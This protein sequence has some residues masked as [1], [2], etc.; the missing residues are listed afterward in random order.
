MTTAMH[1]RMRLPLFSV[2]FIEKSQ[3]TEIKLLLQSVKVDT[4]ESGTKTYQP[5]KRAL[6]MRPGLLVVVLLCGMNASHA[7]SSLEQIDR[8]AEVYAGLL[9]YRPAALPGPRS[10]GLVEI[11]AELDLLPPVNNQIGAKAEPVQTSPVIGRARIDW[12]PLSGLRLGAYLIPPVSILGSTARMLG[13]QVEYGCGR[14][15]I[16][17]S[18]RVFVTQGTVTGSFT[19]SGA[20][21]QFRVSATGAD[22]RSGWSTGKWMLYAGLGQGRNQTQFRMGTDGAIID[23]QRDYSYALAGVGWTHGPW[24]LVAEQQHTVAYLSNI[25]LTVTYGF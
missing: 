22:L 6:D 17:S 11:A 5:H 10:K 13:A 25:I 2:P 12:S 15:N 3:H 14:E 9:D 8:L 19:D 20:T 18:V 24:V 1:S 4:L 21:D 23:G 16:R 7:V